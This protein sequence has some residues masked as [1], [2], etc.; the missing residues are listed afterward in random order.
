MNENWGCIDC[1]F[2][3]LRNWAL[4]RGIIGPLDGPEEM[5]NRIMKLPDRMEKRIQDLQ[6]EI[7]GSK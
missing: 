3:K 2:E 7:N 5:A 4:K 6:D 1:S